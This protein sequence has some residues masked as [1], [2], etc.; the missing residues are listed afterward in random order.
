M[1]MS[2]VIASYIIDSF[3]S[4]TDDFV[5][6][7]RNSLAVQIGC[8]PSQINYVLSSRFTPEQGYLVESRRGGGGYIRIQRVRFTTQ[9]SVL[10]HV[11]NALDDAVTET[12]AIAVIQNLN[13]E[14]WIQPQ[15]AYAMLGAVS[16]RAL[17]CI[18]PHSR[19]SVRASLMKHML[20]SVL[21]HQKAERKDAE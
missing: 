1:R 18:P 12:A 7:Q 2:D 16:D 21:I 10:M 11:I 14:G 15:T 8:S 6:L 20:A 13:S 5:E 19:D 9:P 4:A 3:A 17:Q